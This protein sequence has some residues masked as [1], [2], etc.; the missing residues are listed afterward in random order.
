V[1]FR[2]I[3]EVHEYLSSKP[4]GGWTELSEISRILSRH[5]LTGVEAELLLDFLMKYFLEFDA[6][7]NS[8]R[9]TRSF[10]DFWKRV[11]P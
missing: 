4:P 7:T 11:R 6:R 9:L 8:V 3:D 1:V 10:Y 2:L 5:N